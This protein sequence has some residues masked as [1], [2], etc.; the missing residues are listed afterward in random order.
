MNNVINLNQYRKTKSVKDSLINVSNVEPVKAYNKY[1]E[2]TLE[3][4]ISASI[5][6][7]EDDKLDIMFHGVN[8]TELGARKY[9]KMVE[10]LSDFE[11]RTEDYIITAWN[12]MSG[13][14]YWKKCSE[15]GE[16]NYINITVQLL[17]KDGI[18]EP[19]L[20]DDIDRTVDMFKGFISKEFR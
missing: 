10:L 17:V 13:Y 14:K 16:Y 7:F 18:A 4:S 2:E 3:L 5:N 12:D 19:K 11:I 9:A 8:A 15:A 20:R 6:A 1:F